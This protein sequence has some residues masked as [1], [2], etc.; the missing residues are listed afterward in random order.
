MIKVENH[1][2]ESGVAESIR[3]KASAELDVWS[4]CTADALDALDALDRIWCSASCFQGS[5]SAL[6]K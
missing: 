2:E 3:G 4:S 5:I 1:L 6:G